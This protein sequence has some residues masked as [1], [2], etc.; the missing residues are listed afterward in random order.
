MPLNSPITLIL[1][2][3]RSRAKIVLDF[4]WAMLVET[5]KEPGGMD[6]LR[7]ALQDDGPADDGKEANTA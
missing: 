6:R 1:Q 5:L 3:E 4:E 2:R 7:L